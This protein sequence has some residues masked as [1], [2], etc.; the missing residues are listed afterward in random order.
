MLADKSV[1][2]AHFSNAFCVNLTPTKFCTSPQTIRR[3]RKSEA[4][5]VPP[6]LPGDLKGVALEAWD[7]R[8]HLVRVCGWRGA[9]ASVVVID[10]GF[11]RWIPP[12]L[13]HTG[14]LDTSVPQLLLYAVTK[15]SN[16]PPAS[17]PALSDRLD[18]SVAYNMLA[19]PRWQMQ[20]FLPTKPPTTSITERR[21]RDGNTRR[22]PIQIG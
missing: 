3:D 15:M 1:P 21:V 8:D 10:V 13:L 4:G 6:E 18:N 11:V 9:I 17:S 19:L 16:L 14:E 2:D 7:L 20:F 5:H 22:H 12:P